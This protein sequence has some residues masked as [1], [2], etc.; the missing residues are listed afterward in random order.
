M[1]GSNIVCPNDRFRVCSVFS[2]VFVLSSGLCM[3]DLVYA[4]SS[5]PCMFCLWVHVSS[6]S[7]SAYFLSL[8][9][10]MFCLRF[11]LLSSNDPTMLPLYFYQPLCPRLCLP[12][13]V[14]SMYCLCSFHI[15]IGIVDQLG[16]QGWWKMLRNGFL[17]M[18][19]PD[20]KINP[21]FLKMMV[22]PELESVKVLST[23]NFL[24]LVAGP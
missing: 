8:V 1:A 13:R 19:G 16:L 2:S 18:Q 3:F 4:L 17:H 22:G 12:L 20:S 7:W 23:I 24:L 9:P 6:I 11:C 21:N 5:V 15:L 14:M 10:C